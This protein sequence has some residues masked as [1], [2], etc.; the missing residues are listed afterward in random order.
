LL[1]ERERFIHQI[2]ELTPVVITV[3]DLVTEP[4]NFVRIPRHPFRTEKHKVNK[5]RILLAGDHKIM[6]GGLRMLVNAQADMEVI[7][8][9][10]NGSTAVALAQKLQPDVVIMDISM[11]ELN[12]LK[13]TE[14][15]KG[16]CPDI[17]ILTLTRHKDD[18]YLLQLLQA[19]ASGD[20]LKNSAS[21]ELI[22]AASK[23]E[24]A[25]LGLDR[26]LEALREQRAWR[27][28]YRDGFAARGTECTNCGALT[29]SENESCAYCGKAVR[30]VGD[31][32]E[33]AD[34]RIMVMHGHVEHVRGAA[35]IRLEEV[36]SIGAFLRY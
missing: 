22:T 24:Q 23:Q 17:K 33:R 36:G 9:A 34:T 26:T 27:L 3:F 31:L 10:D 21:E 6:R 32:V 19:G 14:K 2:T 12:G 1:H 11:P 20:V 13:A 4:D 30:E 15:L 8:E 29:V 28:V 5:L 18:G 25:V 35:V 7:G 16:L